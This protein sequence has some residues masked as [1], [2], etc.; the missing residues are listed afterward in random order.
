[1]EDPHQGNWLAAQTLRHGASGA[2]AMHRRATLFR[3]AIAALLLVAVSAGV[4]LL[5]VMAGHR[6]TTSIGST[7]GT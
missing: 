2:K 6:H 3:L 4:L 5:P 7:S 1:M